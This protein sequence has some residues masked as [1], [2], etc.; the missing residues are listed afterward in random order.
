[1]TLPAQPP[2]MPAAPEPLDKIVQIADLH[3]WHVVLNPLR[4][5]SK[6]F[7]GNLNVLLYRRHEF[8]MS[9]AQE[10]ADNVT[11]TGISVALMTGDFTSTANREEYKMASTFVQGLKTK[12]LRIELV[13]GNHDVYTFR[14][15]RTKR[16]EQYFGEFIPD[17]GYPALERLPGGTPLILVPT[18]TPNALSSKGRITDA[19]VAKVSELLKQCSTNVIVAGHYPVLAR[20]YAYSQQESHQLRNAEALH[21]VLGESGCRILYVCGHTHRFSYVQ[22][23][24]YPNLS[25]LSTGA[26]F[27]SDPQAGLQGEF[28]EIHAT[29]AGFA[30][31]RH[32]HEEEWR[33]KAIDIQ[34]LVRD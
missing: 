9:R 7:I 13:P 4:L 23:A 10:F 11:A 18:V 2:P 28:A 14:T 17:G 24:Q 6:R 20:T 12:G 15:L 19:E 34:P 33:R 31:F 8:L 26:F 22:D 29:Q 32:T 16:F 25:H 27:R 5:L 21:R 30:V 3:F 1:V